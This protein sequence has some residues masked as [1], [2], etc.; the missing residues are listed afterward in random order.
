[1]T[2]KIDFKITDA[3]SGA[4][5]TVK[6][7]TRADERELAG[8]EDDG[9]LR[10]RLTSPSSD[11]A[12]NQELIEFLAELLDCE[13]D[14]FEIVAGENSRNKWITVEGVSPNVVEEKLGS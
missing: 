2:R 10:V 14:Q 1:M 12:A 8:V 6:I 5:F 4:A 3:S 9:S 11:G 7:V 13:A